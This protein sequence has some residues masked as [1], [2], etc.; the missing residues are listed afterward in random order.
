MLVFVG[1]AA[2]VDFFTVIDADPL[3]SAMRV[4]PV[5]VPSN[6]IWRKA[7]EPVAGVDAPPSIVTPAVLI[8]CLT[9]PYSEVVARRG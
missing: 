9:L 2:K 8:T 7:F 5:I 3:T 6:G 1:K 4:H